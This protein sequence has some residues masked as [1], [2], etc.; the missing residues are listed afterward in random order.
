MRY[1]STTFLL[2]LSFLR[3]SLFDVQLERYWRSFGNGIC[4]TAVRLWIE[5]RETGIEPVTSSLGNWLA[6]EN[7]THPV[8]GDLSESIEIPEKI[9]HR[10]TVVLTR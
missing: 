7:K 2:D 9:E 10:N 6:I 4:E 8:Y 1:S 5:K 3:S